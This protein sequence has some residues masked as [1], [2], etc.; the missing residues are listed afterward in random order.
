MVHDQKTL[1]DEVSGWL[2]VYDDGSVDRTWAGP[3]EVKF[4]SEPM[5]HHH[6]FV[7]GVA[8]ADVIINPV[9]G[10]SVR[11]YLPEKNPTDLDKF[12]IVLHFHGG[13]FCVSRADWFLYYQMY[14]K[15]AR[16]ARAI[17]VSVYLRLAPENRLPAACDD[18]FEALQWLGS[19]SRAESHETWL[20]QHADF[21]RVFLIGDSSGGNVVHEVA[22]R[23]GHVDLS[24]MKLSGAIPIHPGFFR[25]ERSKSEL[26]QPESQFLTLNIVDKFLKLALPVN[27]TKDHPITCPMGAEAPPL[28]ELKL[29]PI[30]LC[31]AE[32]DLMKDTEMEYY[33]G[34]TKAQKEVELLISPGMGHSFY[35]N[36]IAVDLDPNTSAQTS[37]LIQGISEF[38]H[39]H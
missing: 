4:I 11:I 17:V 19:L 23:A 9:S 21:N 16:S 10:L 22:A 36:K 8:T 30:L 26:E 38:I 15:L 18:G 39:A 6:H 13:C 5:P 34:L 20:D 37:G 28:E 29:P 12:P 33:Q 31:L 3:P 25:S 35:L 27:C 7:D 14:T 32:N 1:V 24:P 2:R